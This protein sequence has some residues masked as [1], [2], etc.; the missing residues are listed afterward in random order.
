MSVCYLEQHFPSPISASW[1]GRI[2]STFSLLSDMFCFLCPTSLAVAQKEC[3]KQ[4]EKK[5]PKATKASPPL[6]VPALSRQTQNAG[7]VVFLALSSCPTFE[8]CYFLG[9]KGKKKIPAAKSFECFLLPCFL[10]PSCSTTGC[11]CLHSKFNHQNIVRCIGV[12]LQALPRFILLELMAG[13][14]LKSFLRETRPRPV[15]KE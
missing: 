9:G 4:G 3:R 14:D 15:R 8:N 10:G 2:K 6:S 7:G 1:M 13:G 5:Q 12:S 11:P